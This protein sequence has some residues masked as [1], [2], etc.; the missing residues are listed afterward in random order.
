MVEVVHEA[1]TH[2]V[3]QIIPR[4]LPPVVR[5]VAGEVRF[6]MSAT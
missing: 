1:V 4:I 3:S 2:P 5:I 6:A